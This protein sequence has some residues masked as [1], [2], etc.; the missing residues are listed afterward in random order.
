[1]TAVNDFEDP[2]EKEYPEEGIS[3][4]G[5]VRSTTSRNT[6][7]SPMADTNNHSHLPSL[8]HN[9]ECYPY[10]EHRSTNE[11][12]VLLNTHNDTSRGRREGN[13]DVISKIEDCF[14]ALID[15]LHSGSESL[16]I[17]FESRAQ[18]SQWLD[19]TSRNSRRP[20]ASLGVLSFPASSARGAWR[21]STTSIPVH[22]LT[23]SD[24][25]ISRGSS[26]LGTRTRGFGERSRYHKKVCNLNGMCNWLPN[27]LRIKLTAFDHHLETSTTKTLP[28]F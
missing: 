7:L 17:P 25:A 18:R 19:S 24:T 1:M 11:P 22:H 6:P 13:A 9:E 27:V 23:A 15:Q 4:L 26:D 14:A 2:L 28:C 10:P 8:A 20:P 5:S 21:F 16:S 12:V 3:S